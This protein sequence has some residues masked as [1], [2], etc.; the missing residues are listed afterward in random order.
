MQWTKS[1][2]NVE[3]RKKSRISL[4]CNK[5]KK[6]RFTVLFITIFLVE[7]TSFDIFVVKNTLD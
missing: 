5:W 3:N 4:S 7:P 6:F 2:K 1:K